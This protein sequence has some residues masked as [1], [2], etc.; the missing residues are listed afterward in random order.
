ME[1]IGCTLVVLSMI[2]FSVPA[3]GATYLCRGYP[4]T[5]VDTTA[6]ETINGTNGRD[7]IV[8]LGG[9]DDIRGNGGNDVICAGYGRD[10]SGGGLGAD[11][12]VGG[13]G[14]DFLGGGPG[15]DRVFGGAGV[16]SLSGGAGND[17]LIGGEILAGGPDD[18][19]MEGGAVNSPND[20]PFVDYR[21]S[22]NG[23]VVDLGSGSATG[24]GSDTF[25]N[26]GSI[27]GS[28]HHDTLRGFDSGVDSVYVVTIYGLDGDD[29]I[30]GTQGSS[31]SGFGGVLSGDG[32][33]D[34]IDWVGVQR[35]DGGPGSDDLIG[36]GGASIWGS[37]GDDH[38]DAQD[39][40]SDE[41]VDGGANVDTCLIDP[42]ETAT[43]CE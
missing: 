27:F 13:A 14:P 40:S 38:I 7:V 17:R 6:A 11:Q 26:V 18:D 41:Y 24:Q 16:N 15:N 31:S 4:A 28:A 25:K 30:T 12:I 5:I 39:G 10:S 1:R 32:G 35:V 42:G 43:N 3:Q 37:G 29:Q 36:S 8:A 9:D 23:V 22:P 19:Y 20:S 34:F 2:S 21:S 33:S